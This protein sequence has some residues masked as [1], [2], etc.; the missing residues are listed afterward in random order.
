MIMGEPIPISVVITNSNRT[1]N[2]SMPD[3]FANPEH[4]PRIFLFA[5]SITKRVI[6]FTP[7]FWCQSA[8]FMVQISCGPGCVILGD[9]PV[10]SNEAGDWS[11][12]RSHAHADGDKGTKQSGKNRSDLSA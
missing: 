8:K 4:T 5:L 2:G 7:F 10:S 12:S 6:I 3:Q 9:I 1:M 11:Y